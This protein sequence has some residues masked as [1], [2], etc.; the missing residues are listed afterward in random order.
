MI[1]IVVGPLLISSSGVLHAA[2]KEFY[3]YGYDA[4]GLP[5]IST[6]EIYYRKLVGHFDINENFRIEI[7]LGDGGNAA[8]D[9]PNVYFDFWDKVW[10]KDHPGEEGRLVKSIDVN[11]LVQTVVLQGEAAMYSL[12][13]Q[14]IRN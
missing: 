5:T 4:P 8:G 2:K 13:T 7:R 10:D 6:I 14:L 3:H 1:P 12:I 11:L 9:A